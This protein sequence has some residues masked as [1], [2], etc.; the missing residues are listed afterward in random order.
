[1]SAR[2]HVCWMLNFNRSQ[3]TT[4][5]QLSW[6]MTTTTLSTLLLLIWLATSTTTHTIYLAD[7]TLHLPQ[8]SW[9]DSPT[10]FTSSNGINDLADMAP[11]LLQ[12]PW[13]QSITPV[14]LL[15]NC[16]GCS[17]WHPPHS[18]AKLPHHHYALPH[19]HWCGLEPL[20]V[21]RCS[22]FLVC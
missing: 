14:L 17:S 13:L 19:L 10:A 8:P 5:Q 9:R 6:T 11:C 16:H 12:S 22:T 3:T 20:T 4:W 2:D 18:S 21:L 15:F 1:M 7:A